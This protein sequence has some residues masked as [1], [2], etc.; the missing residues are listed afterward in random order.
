MK[1]KGCT[2]A[3]SDERED[4]VLTAFL[5]LA[6]QPTC[7]ALYKAIGDS[8]APRLWISEERAAAVYSLIKKGHN[9]QRAHKRRKLMYEEIVRRVDAIMASGGDNFNKAIAKAIHMPA[10]SFFLSPSTIGTI[11][12]TALRKRGRNGCRR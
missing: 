7:K 3:F 8:P 6:P 12:N 9:M 1:K 10:P 11:L 2:V 5:S 4:A